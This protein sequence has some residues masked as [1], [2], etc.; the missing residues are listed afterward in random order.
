MLQRPSPRTDDVFDRFRLSADG[1]L[2]TRDRAPVSLRPKLLRT[3]LALVERAGRVVPKA[4]VIEE[5]WPD[6]FVDESGLTRNICVLRKALGD[7]GARF[8]ATVARVG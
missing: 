2:L 6:T 5:V 4:V 8:I 1:T 7:D 3:L